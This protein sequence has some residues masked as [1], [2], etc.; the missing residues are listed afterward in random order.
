MQLSIYWFTSKALSPLSPEKGW[1]VLSYFD[2]VSLGEI[3]ILPIIAASTAVLRGI[4]LSHPLGI[5]DDVLLSSKKPLRHLMNFGFGAFLT[6]LLGMT[7][8]IIFY[9]WLTDREFQIAN[10]LTL[11]ILISAAM[12]FFTLLSVL[13]GLLFL[14]YRRGAGFVSYLVMIST[15]VAGVYFPPEVLP[16]WIGQTLKW[17]SPFTIALTAYREAIL[18]GEGPGWI[19]YFWFF[20]GA[21]IL[22]MINSRVFPVAKK[23]YL[24]RRVSEVVVNYV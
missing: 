17:L 20:S 16:D 3:L 12:P 24:S 6:D 10:I 13:A 21:V 9:A 18:S 5:L 15:I 11:L 1:G 7:I 14:S 8:T 4:S 23:R 19:F 22:Y 2:Y